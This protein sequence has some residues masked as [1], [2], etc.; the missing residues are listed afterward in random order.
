MKLLNGHYE[1]KHTDEIAGSEVILGNR[2]V[3]IGNWIEHANDKSLSLK[4][5]YSRSSTRKELD[6]IYYQRGDWF[7][8]SFDDALLFC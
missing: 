6:E 1:L 7:I 4:S 5:E 2:R 3:D 8:F